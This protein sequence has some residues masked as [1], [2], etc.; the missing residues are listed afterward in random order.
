MSQIVTLQTGAEM[1]LTNAPSSL[2][3]V[4]INGGQGGEVEGTW[5]ASLEWLVERLAP[6][7]STLRFAEVRYRIKSWRRLDWCIDDARA[8]IAE[9]GADRTLL[10]GFSMGGAVGIGAVDAPGVEGLVGLAPWI[11]DRMPI[12]TLVGRRLDVL[13][14]SLDRWL[15]GIPGVSAASSRR[16]FERAQALGVPG[17]YTLIPGAV[18]PIALRAPNGKPFPFPRARR[19]AELLGERIDAFAASTTV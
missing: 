9:T 11:P 8:A 3:V 7:H 16:G 19:W 1:R 6:Q 13:H 2:A 18:H 4:C 17:T 14:G 12:D 15:P 10:V 5:S